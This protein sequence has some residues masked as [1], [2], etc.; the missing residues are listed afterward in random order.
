MLWLDTAAARGMTTGNYN[1]VMGQEA[2]KSNT[3]ASNQTAVGHQAAY[4]NTTGPNLTAVGRWALYANT[5]GADNTAVGLNALVSNT[6]GATQIL[7]LD[8][9]HL[10]PTP[11]QDRNHWRLVMKLATSNTTTN[12]VIAVYWH[13]ARA[14]LHTSL[15]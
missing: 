5:T 14:R 6:T 9:R 10:I 1:T 11:P 8:N 7:Q 3:T 12:G 15:V 13:I 2:L 4:S